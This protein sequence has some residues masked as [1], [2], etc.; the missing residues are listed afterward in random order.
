[1]AKSQL[2]QKTTERE[3]KGPVGWVL[4]EPATEFEL[5]FP[6]E[7]EFD[8]PG[9]ASEKAIFLAD[10]EKGVVTGVRRV[11][12]KEIREKEIVLYFDRAF[13]FPKPVELASEFPSFALKDRSIPV[14]YDELERILDA[15]RSLGFPYLKKFGETEGFKENPEPYRNHVRKLLHLAFKSDLLGP[16]EGPFEE[17][18]ASM[19]RSRYLLGRLAPYDPAASRDELENRDL[20]AEI[21]GGILPEDLDKSDKSGNFDL[22]DVNV[23][24]SPKDPN[25]KAPEPPEQLFS[26]STNDEPDDANFEAT[27]HQSLTPSSFGFTFCVDARVKEIELTVSWGVY[28]R[29]DSEFVEDEETGKMAKCWK[30]SPAGGK[31]ILELPRKGANFKPFSIDS[32]QPEVKI[33]GSVTDPIDGATRLVTLFLVNMQRPAQKC[34][35][36]RWLFQPE[37]VVRSPIK[38]EP[39]FRRRAALAMPKVSYDKE[40][41]SLEMIYR[42]RAQFA[43]GHGV[44]VSATPS[45]D[46]PESAVEIRTTV[47]PE[48]EVPITEAPGENDDDRETARIFAK[49]RRLDMMNLATDPR[50]KVIKTLEDL[51][52]DYGVWIYEREKQK[53]DEWDRLEAFGNS[54][55]DS[56]ERCKEAKR[57]ILEGIQTLEKDDNA[58]RAFQFANLAM[59]TQRVHAKYAERRD[60]K[61]TLED[62]DLPKNRTW[63][64]FQLAFILINIP[65]LANP[66]HPERTA[67]VGAPADLL[68]FPTGGGKTEAYLGVAA[69]AMAIRRLQGSLGGL[70]ASR[71][72]TVV[73]RYTYRLLTVQQFQRA[74]ALICAMEALRQDDPKTWGKTP[75]TLGLWVGNKTTPKSP[76]EIETKI[77]QI[78]NKTRRPDDDSLSLLSKC[79]WCG[80]ECWPGRDCK[81]STKE[82][83]VRF[84][85]GDRDGACIFSKDRGEGNGFP[86]LID[87]ESIY[88]RP[89]S[90]L[91]ATV[92]KFATLAWKQEA[93]TLFGKARR[94]CDRCGLVWENDHTSH[95]PTGTLKESRVRPIKAIRP[96]DLIVQD[97]FHLISGALGTMVGLY[98]SAVDD[99]CSWK[100]NDTKI[101]P[102]IVAS[103]A[104]TRKADAQIKQVFQRKVEIFPPKCLDVEDDYF[105]VQRETSE[106][107]GRRYVGICAPGTSRPDIMIAAYT[108]LLTAAQSLFLSF[109]ELADPY[110]S[111]VGYFNS[112]RE[113]G[114]ARRMV[115]DDVSS[116]TFCIENSKNVRR[117]GLKNRSVRDVLEL[118]SRVNSR[119]IPQKL[120]QLATPFQ[121]ERNMLDKRPCDVVLATNML[122][123]G[124]DIPRL[125][126]MVVNGQPKNT[127]E[128][129]QATSRVGR[130]V[131]GFV[132]TVFAWSRPRD[133]S[134]YE[135]FEHYC[136]TFY[137]HV[138]AQSVTPF[139][140]RA[141]DRGFTGAMV[142]LLRV[143]IDELSPN[144]GAFEMR[145]PKTREKALAKT[146]EAICERAGNVV[147][148]AA[149]DETYDR[150][151]DRID[152]WKDEAK[153][154]QRILGYDRPPRKGDVVELLKRPNNKAWGRFTVAT[155]MREVEP[156]LNLL[157]DS[158]LQPENQPD[159]DFDPKE[160]E[161][162]DNE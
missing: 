132:V 110:M 41:T 116:R 89:P 79:P 54:S 67:R 69:F 108:T 56:I 138:E 81:P 86:I 148:L 4:F 118:T 123:V 9:F 130:G 124:L 3:S 19:V 49:E 73:M 153:V 64:T 16:A 20:E 68:W 23:E 155:S 102:K 113:L 106:R 144:E 157:M 72:L 143:G 39:I 147:G 63:R 77:R 15:G 58:F 112:L 35:D 66:S 83:R 14:K 28:A 18:L 141:L 142:S 99:L 125:G 26:D 30:R 47:M 17:V 152:H 12:V 82:A 158:E 32:N 13:D 61:Q 8:D 53:K 121:I 105:S 115:E 100:W 162:N 96:P 109:G 111:L 24:H 146:V 78:G 87:D 134:H 140:A 62:F 136:A 36:E 43:T 74:A 95:R 37:M 126:L 128:Y 1:M 93:R 33:Q 103:T 91:I 31:T 120:T 97:E 156:D 129:V 34:Q 119:D 154:K 151:N 2:A 57:R 150:L 92:D 44:S 98:E 159:W 160:K 161:E 45:R 29:T 133:F 25:G 38:G 59:A 6:I 149:R 11:Y 42:N 80:S 27:A 104:T 139:S 94:E 55:D 10:R 22:T 71:G 51:A 88:R 76:D 107:P 52:K 84:F 46:D 75:F 145:D 40:A 135:M 7:S 65:A 85:C 114:T 127:A 60:E 131:P 90:M 5:R 101:R 137:K 122:S 21:T 117:P 48:Y 50:P 70:D